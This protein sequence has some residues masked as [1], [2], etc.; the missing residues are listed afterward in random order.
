MFE[1]RAMCGS[2]SWT[3]LSQSITFWIWIALLIMALM[4][5]LVSAAQLRHDG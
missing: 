4:A 3:F 5:I 2:V 1:P